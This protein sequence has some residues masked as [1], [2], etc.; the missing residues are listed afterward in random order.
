VKRFRGA[1]V[2]GALAL[3]LFGAGCGGEQAQEGRGEALSLT[4]DADRFAGPSPLNVKFSAKPKGAVGEVHYR[5]RFDDGTHS[6]DPGPTHSFTR[7]GYYTVVVDAR[8][9]SGNN[10]RQ[11]MLLGAWP[12]RQWAQSQTR[13]ITPRYARRIQRV[14]QQRTDARHDDLRKELRRRIRQG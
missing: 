5:W 11:S 9:E 14:Q 4:V 3:A 10:A 7:P 1:L 8:D 12:P 2:P 13:R 6:E